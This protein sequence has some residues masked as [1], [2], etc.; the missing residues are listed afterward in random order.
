[1]WTSDYQVD[2]KTGQPTPEMHP[3]L[4]PN[5]RAIADLTVP[6]VEPLKTELVKRDGR[7]LV[8]YSS[9]EWIVTC[10]DLDK[11]HWRAGAD[12]QL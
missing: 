2:H 11:L 9:D 1:M 4:R 7:W 10:N 6:H 8:T 12:A 5:Q 3:T